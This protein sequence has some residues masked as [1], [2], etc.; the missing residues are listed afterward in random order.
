MT[1]IRRIPGAS[2]KSRVITLIIVF[3]NVVLWLPR[4]VI[5][6]SVG[7]FANPNGAGYIFPPN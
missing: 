5:P 1:M 3:P 2:C 7:C 4:L 6:Q